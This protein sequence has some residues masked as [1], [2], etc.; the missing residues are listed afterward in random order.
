MYKI[1]SNDILDEEELTDE[2]IL[3][4]V[5]LQ[6]EIVQGHNIFFLHRDH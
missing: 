2:L 5:L 4:S 1:P 6:S 3:D